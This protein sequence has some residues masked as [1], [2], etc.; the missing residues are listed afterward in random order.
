MTTALDYNP[1]DDEIKD[2]Q[3]CLCG[4]EWIWGSLDW[5]QEIKR[6]NPTCIEW[7]LAPEENNPW[8]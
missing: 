8:G 5:E 7:I 2:A 6:N 3:Y 4:I 1:S